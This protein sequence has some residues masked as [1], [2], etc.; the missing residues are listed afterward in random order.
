MTKFE[1]AA[2]FY[3]GSEAKASKAGA[4]KDSRKRKRNPAEVDALEPESDEEP[5][6]AVEASDE[7]ERQKEP[8]NIFIAKAVG[9]AAKHLEHS[10]RGKVL[11]P[12]Y[13]EWCSVPRPPDAGVAYLDAG[14][15]YDKNSSSAVTRSSLQDRKLLYLAIP[16]SLLQKQ[17]G[18][19]PVLESAQEVE[20]LLLLL[21]LTNSSDNN[22]CSSLTDSGDS[23]S[24]SRSLSLIP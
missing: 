11:V 16:H 14:F 12:Y 4:K 10:L 19:D 24:S 6:E 7:Q 18:V 23:S 5:E 9:S 20:L 1:D 8:W 2:V 17:K 15:F 13:C 21:L 22:S 3:V